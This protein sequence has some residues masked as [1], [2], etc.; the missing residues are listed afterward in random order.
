MKRTATLGVVVHPE[1]LNVRGAAER[2]GVEP[3]TVYRLIRRGEL[4]AHDFGGYLCVKIE[5]ADRV[6][7]GLVRDWSLNVLRARLDEWNRAVES[8]TFDDAVTGEPDPGLIAAWELE[9]GWTRG[10]LVANCEVWADYLD[11]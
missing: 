11:E 4:P 3:M 9:R 10:E 5:D 2:I 8:G 7:P 6:A 1:F